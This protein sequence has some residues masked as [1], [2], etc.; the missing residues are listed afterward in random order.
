MS[1]SGHA[2]LNGQKRPKGSQD[3]LTRLG[4]VPRESCKLPA[5]QFWMRPRHVCVDTNTCTHLP[6][7]PLWPSRPAGRPAGNRR[8]RQPIT[9][10]EPGALTPHGGSFCGEL[11]HHLLPRTPTRLCHG[12]PQAGPRPGRTRSLPTL[13]AVTNTVCPHIGSR[14]PGLSE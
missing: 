10:S 5:K 8:D 13:A 4:I 11:R 7:P 3:K 2:Q 9:Q 14:C 6:L 1:Q 12:Q